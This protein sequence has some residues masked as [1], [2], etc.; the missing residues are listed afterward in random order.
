VT[1]LSLLY[2]LRNCAWCDSRNNIPQRVVCQTSTLSFLLLCFW[3]TAHWLC[4]GFFLGGGSLVTKCLSVRQ[5][6]ALSD[7]YWP[8]ALHSS[9][10]ADF[11]NSPT[12]NKSEG[13]M[14][15]FFPGVIPVLYHCIQ[16]WGIQ[17]PVKCL[18]ECDTRV[19]WALPR[20]FL[21]K[22]ESFEKKKRLASWW[23]RM[24]FQRIE[25]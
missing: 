12:T 19:R 8:C 4:F 1:A 25:L 21:Y 5:G 24:L 7:E 2:Y 20:P 6:T 18:E 11:T 15:S 10:L 23:G 3:Q 9:V 14:I 22:H 13:Q 16:N 17:E